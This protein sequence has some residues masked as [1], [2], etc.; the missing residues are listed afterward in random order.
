MFDHGSSVVDREQILSELR[1]KIGG[2]PGAG[3]SSSSAPISVP[4]RSAVPRPVLAVPEPLADVLPSGGL[5]RGGVVS[6]VGDSGSTSLLFSLLAA[7]S[8]AWSAVVGMPNLGL[9]AAAEQGVDL[10]RLVL[11]PDPGLDVLQVLS[12]LADGVDIIAAVPPKVLP[13]ARL[14]VLG[15]RL[16]QSGAVLL[17]AGSWPGAELV[18]RSRV[19]NWTGIG[20][21][22]GRL[23]DRELVVEVGGRG[24]ARGRGSVC[25]LLQSTRA[26]V[27]VVAAP[28]VERVLEPLVADVG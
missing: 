7:P 9:L 27:T 19:E 26:A 25:M 24:A 6:L 1:R 2:A 23:R 28:R 18:L 20:R 22:H 13:P 16:R 17:V 5:P 4:S 3:G 15:A 12:V 11:I 8:N 14:R 10:D 21:G